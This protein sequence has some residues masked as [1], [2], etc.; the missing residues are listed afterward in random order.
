MTTPWNLPRLLPNHPHTQFYDN[1]LRDDDDLS[2]DVDVVV[3]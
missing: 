3:V 1:P 2:D